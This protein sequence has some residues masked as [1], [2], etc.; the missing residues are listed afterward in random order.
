VERWWQSWPEIS[1]KFTKEER[2]EYGL[3]QRGFW[4]MLEQTIKENGHD[5]RRPLE[6]WTTAVGCLYTELLQMM[7]HVPVAPNQPLSLA[8]FAPHRM[9]SERS[10]FHKS[11]EQSA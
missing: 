1:A 4:N 2:A 9:N 11:T 8:H 10:Q 3:I 7:I 6:C 5:G